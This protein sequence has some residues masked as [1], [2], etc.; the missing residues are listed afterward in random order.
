M[1][2]APGQGPTLHGANP[3]STTPQLRSEDDSSILPLIVSDLPGAPTPNMMSPALS[4]SSRNGVAD[5]QS[6]R[7]TATP[8][9]VNGHRASHTPPAPALAPSPQVVNQQFPRQPTPQM[10]S[11]LAGVP[12]MVPQPSTHAHIAHQSP[13]A[14]GQRPVSAVPLPQGDPRPRLIAQ[15][16]ATRPMIVDPPGSQK[17]V[18]PPVRSRTFMSP[19]P[20]GTQ[21]PQYQSSKCQDDINRLTHAV[22]QSLP[23]AVRSVVRDTWEKCL[24]GTD[25]H[26]AFVVGHPRI[27]VHVHRADIK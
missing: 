26:Q 19:G 16:V 15:K 21:H 13:H 12:S 2:T 5:Q 11:G 17:A 3:P 6:G 24:L 9:I 27:L 10:S 8:P 4:A 14:F 25:F 23:E 22:Q 20:E 1:S 18:N 7:T